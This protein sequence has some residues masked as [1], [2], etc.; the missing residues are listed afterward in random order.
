MNILKLTVCLSLAVVLSAC[1]TVNLDGPSNVRIYKDSS[2]NQPY[3][4]TTSEDLAR[5]GNTSQR[6]EVRHGDCGREYDCHNDRRRV[7]LSESNNY[8]ARVGDQVWY[9]WSIY[10]PPDFPDISPAN[11]FLG[12]AKLNETML[13]SFLVRDNRIIFENRPGDI[14]NFSDMPTQ[15]NATTLSKMQGQ[16]TDI[17]VYADYSYENND[18]SD[19]LKVWINNK[20]VC[21]S[22]EP[23]MSAQ[24]TR[25]EGRTHVQLRYGIYNGFISE[26]HRDTGINI[27]PTQ[28]AY[29]DNVRTG[30]TRAEVDPN[31]N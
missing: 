22:K 23:V 16:W 2:A 9:G 4:F 3:G 19:M 29:Y 18:N 12:Q 27:L 15:C 21:T 25:S 20:L 1:Q 13:W 30:K 26:Y 8:H 17:V 5:T 11:T 7:E 28:I 6:F 14:N 31:L 10:L 24:R